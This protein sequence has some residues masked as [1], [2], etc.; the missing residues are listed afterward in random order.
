MGGFELILFIIDGT[1]EHGRCRPSL[2]VRLRI[3]SFA[4]FVL[5]TY[6]MYMHSPFFF[7]FLFQLLSFKK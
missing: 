6:Y 2:K 5:K 4:V 1:R 3:E 7:L